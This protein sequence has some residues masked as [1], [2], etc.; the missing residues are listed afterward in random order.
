MVLEAHLLLG[1]WSMWIL[2][3]CIN[4]HMIYIAHILRPLVRLPVMQDKI[5][6]NRWWWRYIRQIRLQM[7][8]TTG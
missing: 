2:Y 8:L 3:I 7:L 1:Q 4:R 5:A 6:L